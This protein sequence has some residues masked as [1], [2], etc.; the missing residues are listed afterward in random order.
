MARSYV[1]GCSH[2]FLMVS[3]SFVQVATCG[4]NRSSPAPL[5][6]LLPAQTMAPIRCVLIFWPIL[7]SAMYLT[8]RLFFCAPKSLTRC[9]FHAWV[10]MHCPLL[11]QY[12]ENIVAHSAGHANNGQDITFRVAR[13]VGGE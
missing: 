8:G 11:L 6:G 9:A 2:A 5:C 12:L 7:L 10:F 3:S 4:T 13:T 1:G